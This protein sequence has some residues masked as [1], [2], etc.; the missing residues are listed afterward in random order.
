MCMCVYAHAHM[1]WYSHT[2][3]SL[4]T[5]THARTHTHTVVLA[6]QLKAASGQLNA[7][8]AIRNITS[9]EQSGDNLV[10]YYSYGAD[11]SRKHDFIY[12]SFAAPLG[13]TNGPSKAYVHVHLYLPFSLFV[14]VC[15]CVEI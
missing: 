13:N 8:L 3:S 2:L 1:R 11:K 7:P 10:T 14:C 5:H 12:V 6:R 4:H 15:V 9:I